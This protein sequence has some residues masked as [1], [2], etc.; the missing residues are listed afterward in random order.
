MDKLGSVTLRPCHYPVPQQRFIPGFH[1][2]R[3]RWE[4]Q[5]NDFLIPSFSIEYYLLLLFCCFALALW[6]WRKERSLAGVIKETSGRGWHW[7]SGRKLKRLF[8]APIWGNRDLLQSQLRC[9]G[10]PRW[11]RHSF[12]QSSAGLCRHT[13]EEPCWGEVGQELCPQSGPQVGRL[14]GWQGKVRLWPS[15]IDPA[16]HLSLVPPRPSDT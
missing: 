13:H 9:P 3:L 8:W 7:R 1:L 15:S 10:W 5:N 6:I 4:L 12:L 14:L 2:T 16:G 11:Q